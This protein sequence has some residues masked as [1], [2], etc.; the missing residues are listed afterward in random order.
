VYRFKLV[1]LGAVFELSAAT[2]ALFIPN[3]L[4]VRLKSLTSSTLRP[5][6][7][8]NILYIIMTNPFF[9]RAENN[10]GTKTRLLGKAGFLIG[11]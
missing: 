11:L 9:R 5:T 10:K 7:V 4:A 8:I 1:P 3:L 2:M 6:E